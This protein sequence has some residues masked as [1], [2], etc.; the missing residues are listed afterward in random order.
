MSRL[1]ALIGLALAALAA[2]EARAGCSVD[3]TPVTFGTIDPTRGDDSTG[4]VKV[5]CDQGTIFLVGIGPG[6]NGSNG[7]RAMDGPGN[8]KMAYNLYIDAGHHIVWGDGQTLGQYLDGSASAS[9]PWSSTIYG[10]IPSQSPKPA[11]SYADSL[12]VSVDF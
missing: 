10:Q 11:G 12:L 6:T 8:A 2:G 3:L 1:P 4:K 7:N 5:S 9:A